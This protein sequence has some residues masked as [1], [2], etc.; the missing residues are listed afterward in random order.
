MSEKISSACYSQVFFSLGI[1][2][3]GIIM[4]GSYNKFNA[5]KETLPLIMLFF[6]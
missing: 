3:G 5:R 6:Y 1:S 4:L 2:W